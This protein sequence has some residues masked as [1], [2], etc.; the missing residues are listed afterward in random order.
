MAK[1]KMV[2]KTTR[3]P[4]LREQVKELWKE[5]RRL[6]AELAKEKRGRKRD[7]VKARS[8][9]QAR[10]DVAAQERA[11]LWEE[12]RLKEQFKD[13]VT[14]LVVRISGLER[15]VEGRG[16]KLREQ[17]ARSE[18]EVGQLRWVFGEL[19]KRVAD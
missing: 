14:E 3:K 19:V 8:V 4:T 12:T 2:K 1:K 9:L 5:N 10:C 18:G 13:R 17:E 7:E 6:E 11:E 16:G 15:E